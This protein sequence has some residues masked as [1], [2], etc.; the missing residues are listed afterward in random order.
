VI[1]SFLVSDEAE[2]FEDLMI[3]KIKFFSDHFLKDVTN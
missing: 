1:E 2:N 3:L